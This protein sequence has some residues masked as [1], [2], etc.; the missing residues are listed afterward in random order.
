[1]T[2]RTKK[3]SYTLVIGAAGAVAGIAFSYLM[4]ATG[5]T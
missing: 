2:E 4:G 3:I 5:S 1:M